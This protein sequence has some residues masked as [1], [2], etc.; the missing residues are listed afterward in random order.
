[1]SSA[2][3]R[4]SDKSRNTLRELA[5]KS[6][7]PMQ[8]VLDRIIEEHRRRVF[9]DEVNAAYARIR[10]DPE[11]WAE[12][13]NERAKWDATLMDGLDPNERWT[14]DGE[15]TFRNADDAAAD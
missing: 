9:L 2:T 1:M 6:G 7:E 11:A 15:V 5:S 14:A 8:S 4:I 13:L 10:Q 12:V 3:V